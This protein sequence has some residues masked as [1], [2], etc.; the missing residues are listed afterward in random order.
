MKLQSR[1]CTVRMRKKCVKRSTLRNCCVFFTAFF[2]L[3]LCGLS[4][5]IS[6]LF[7]L[8]VLGIV[9]ALISRT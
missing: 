4:F 1:P 7:A 3:L 5:G 2:M 9:C 6:L 8:A